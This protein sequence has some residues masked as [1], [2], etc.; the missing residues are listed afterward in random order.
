MGGW[1]YHYGCL[2]VVHS[3]GVRK[4]ELGARPSVLALFSGVEEHWDGHILMRREGKDRGTM[5]D[6]CSRFDRDRIEP[7]WGGYSVKNRAHNMR[8]PSRA[9]SKRQRHSHFYQVV[10]KNCDRVVS[11]W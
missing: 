9:I 1:I 5:P 2:Q 3:A 11:K 7:V 10:L 4:Q 8:V 6:S